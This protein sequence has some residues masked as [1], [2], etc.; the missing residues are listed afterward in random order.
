MIENKE[1]QTTINSIYRSRYAEG[2]KNSLEHFFKG[3]P[4]QIYSLGRVAFYFALKGLGLKQGDRVLLPSLICKE[5]LHPVYEL[6]LEP[7]FFDMDRF[8]KPVLH[9]DQ[10]PIC[11]V[12]LCVNYFGFPQDIEYFYNYCR[13]TGAVLIEDNAQGFLS[14]DSKKSVL[15]MRGNLG[16]I[17]FRKTFH[18]WDGAV[19]LSPSN[20]SIFQAMPPD[21]F[22]L[23]PLY[24]VKTYLRDKQ[25]LST[26]FIHM[27]ARLKVKVKFVKQARPEQQDGE[28]FKIGIRT[29]SLEKLVAYDWD[30]EI[31]RRRA[32]FLYA[33]DLL[34]PCGALPVFEEI[35]EGTVPYI[36]PFYIE[37]KDFE[38]VASCLAKYSLQCFSWPD[39]PPEVRRSAPDYYQ[40]L[41]GVRFLW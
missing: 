36:F 26:R 6:G 7:V 12:I 27:L 28:I 4:Y 31:K 19:L 14:R 13:R 5:V 38:K 37:N 35:E 21:S 25:I 40:K 9:A 34:K 20:S 16:I 17:S 39:L 24:K 22:P 23:P 18:L 2:R 1:F 29:E 33:K 8:L 32:L 11:K 15:G 10:L 41:Y 30:H 3:C